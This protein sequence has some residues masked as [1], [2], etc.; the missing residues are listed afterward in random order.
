MSDTIRE[1]VV[2]RLTEQQCGLIAELVS[3]PEGASTELY[4]SGLLERSSQ[5]TW[6]TDTS[7]VVSNVGNMTVL[8]YEGRA[9]RCSTFVRL[10]PEGNRMRATLLVAFRSVGVQ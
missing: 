10:S 1:D 9:P 5:L 8:R 2:D 7:A 4:D 3:W 6:A